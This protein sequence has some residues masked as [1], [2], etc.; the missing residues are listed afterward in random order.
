MNIISVVYYRH[1]M[2][3]ERLTADQQAPPLL[4]VTAPGLFNSRIQLSVRLIDVDYDLLALLVNLLHLFFLLYNV[5]VNLCEELSELLHLSFN[6]LDSFM[7]AL[8][9]S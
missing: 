4:P 6:F 3:Y 9:G 8:N 7:S 1:C 2:V 5:F